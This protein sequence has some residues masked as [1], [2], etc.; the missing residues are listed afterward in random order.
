MAAS[1]TRVTVTAMFLGEAASVGAALAAAERKSPLE[2]SGTI[3]KLTRQNDPHLSI[4][5]FVMLM[6]PAC[7]FHPGS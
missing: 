2:V 7:E 1:S 5:S 3:A 6:F 4:L